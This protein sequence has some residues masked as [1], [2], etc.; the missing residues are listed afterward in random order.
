MKHFFRNLL[1]ATVMLGPVGANAA[2]I[3][4]LNVANS[5][6]RHD[7]YAGFY[8]LK[9]DGQSVLGMCDDFST[10]ST[11]GE[12]WTGIVYDY[13][14]LNSGAGKFGPDPTR[15]SQIGYLFSLAP[16]TDYSHQASINEAIWKIMTPTAPKLATLTG[17]ALNYFNSATDG[18]HNSFDYTNYMLAIKP[19]PLNASQEFLIVPG[20]VPPSSVPLPSAVWLL[21]SGFVAMFGMGRRAGNA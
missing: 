14:S 5:Q 9:V 19:Q 2:S 4:L 21:L 8:T 11:I 12:T 20:I 16:A 10:N 17:D 1:I 18:S 3:T 15:Y 7:A 6:A 13:S